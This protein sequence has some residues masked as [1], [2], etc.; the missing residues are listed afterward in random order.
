MFEGYQ[1]VWGLANN[2]MIKIM[3]KMFYIVVQRIKTIKMLFPVTASKP[4]NQ[5]NKTSVVRPIDIL[6]GMKLTVTLV[7]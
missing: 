5:S 7:L 2:R 4:S 3:K 1:E 6:T